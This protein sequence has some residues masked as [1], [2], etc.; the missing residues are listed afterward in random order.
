[1]DKT[2]AF[3]KVGTACFILVLGDKNPTDGEWSEY[4]DF[5]RKHLVPGVEP[6][7]IVKTNGGSPS[8]AQRKLL[9]EVTKDYAKSA[10]IAVLT[11]STIARGAVTALSWFTPGYAA[12]NPADIDVYDKA[13]DFL[14]MKHPSTLA[15]EVKGTLRRHEKTFTK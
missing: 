11:G 4:L 9:N 3:E 14:G 2:L 13:L 12:F 8:P 7:L 15:A 6:R 10:K 5:L 1:M